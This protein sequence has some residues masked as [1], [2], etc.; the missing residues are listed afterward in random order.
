[1][2]RPSDGRRREVG[3]GAPGLAA[4]LTRATPARPGA[5]RRRP[6]TRPPACAP[7]PARR[8]SGTPRRGPRPGGSPRAGGGGGYSWEGR[9]EPSCL[10]ERTGRP[11]GRFFCGECHGSGSSPAESGSLSSVAHFVP[12]DAARPCSWGAP[13]G[14]SRRRM[15]Y[16]MSHRSLPR[17]AP[18]PNQPTSTYLSTTWIGVSGASGPC[19]RPRAGSLSQ[20]WELPSLSPAAPRTYPNFCL[21]VGGPAFLHVLFCTRT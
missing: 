16:F 12:P 11:R 5:A 19:S 10:E 14:S 3:A 6:G 21:P 8:R 2:A 7:R 4:S 9:L 18:T 13:W 17:S 15:V 20:Q 1:M